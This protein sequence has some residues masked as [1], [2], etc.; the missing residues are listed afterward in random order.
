[1]CERRRSGVD[2]AWREVNRTHGRE[3]EGVA[4]GDQL[5]TQLAT[6]PAGCLNKKNQTCTNVG[7]TRVSAVA[8]SLY[9]S[10]YA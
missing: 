2:A 1:M 4:R 10:V 3:A 8:L 5:S 9:P 6:V 7:S